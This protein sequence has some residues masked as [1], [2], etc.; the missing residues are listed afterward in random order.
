MSDTDREQHDKALSLLVK[1]QRTLIR[2]LGEYVAEN[3]SSL[4]LAA[5]GAEGYGYTVHQLDEL[6]LSRLNLVERTIAELQKFPT[7]GASRYRTQCFVASRG[8]VEQEINS[9]LEKLT[10]AR[11]LGVSVSPAAGGAGPDGPAPDGGLEP[12]AAE[13]DCDVADPREDEAPAD[14]QVEGDGSPG[15]QLLVTVLYYGPAPRTT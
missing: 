1:M 2:R 8:E 3:E 11:I 6:F 5:D 10:D 7:G 12:D 13:S 9:R 14:A 4:R 15:D